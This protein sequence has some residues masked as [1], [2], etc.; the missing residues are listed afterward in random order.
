MQLLDDHLWDLYSRGWISVEDM[1]D[2]C[3]SQPAMIEK[4]KR[5]GQSIGRAEL[6]EEDVDV[7]GGD[8]KAGK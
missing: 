1:I 8:A 6:D 4:V 7:K 5:A 2:K 3:R